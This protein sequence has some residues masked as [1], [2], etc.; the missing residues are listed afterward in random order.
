MISRDQ[1]YVSAALGD[2]DAA[3][4]RNK[5]ATWFLERARIKYFNLEKPG[6]AA[7]DY[8]AAAREAFSYRGFRQMLDGKNAA[9]DWM[10]HRRPFYPDGLYLMLWA[11]HARVRAGQ[12]DAAE[13][14]KLGNELAQPIWR[15]IV[16]E[17]LT[18]KDD[19]RWA[20]ARLRAL[21]PWPGPL[22]LMLLQQIT[23]EAARA[24]ASGAQDD[25][26]ARRSCDA[27]FY[28]GEFEL[29]RGRLEQAQPLLLS[30]AARCPEGAP[31]AGFAKAEIKRLG[32]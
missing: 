22:Y 11:H 26:K 1:G 32:W 21:K 28:T 27:D 16:F 17:N 7:D 5:K 10:E 23:T 29:G 12:D 2:L 4:S 14:A 18:E 25:A 30:A 13:M 6:E 15:E 19:D 8:V 9:M 24:E 20:R 31:E 3:L